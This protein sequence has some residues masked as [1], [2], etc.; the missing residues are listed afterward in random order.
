MLD[1]TAAA[2]YPRGLIMRYVHQGTRYQTKSDFM[3]HEIFL[4]KITV[5]AQRENLHV[6]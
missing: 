6:D 1:D 3:E 4:P 2:A 5:P